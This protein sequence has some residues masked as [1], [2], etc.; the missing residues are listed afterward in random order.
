MLVT[1]GGALPSNSSAMVLEPLRR[2]GTR[3]E[4]RDLPP[5]WLTASREAGGVSSRRWSRVLDDGAEFS[6]QL[7]PDTTTS[8]FMST[9]EQSVEHRV[10]GKQARATA[11]W[12][13]RV[14]LTVP[15]RTWPDCVSPVPLRSTPGRESASTSGSWSRVRT[16]MSMP[17]G[18]AVIVR[19]DD[20][21]RPMIGRRHARERQQHRAREDCEPTDTIAVA[22]PHRQRPRSRAICTQFG[23]GAE[24]RRAEG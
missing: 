15:N 16:R 1:I 20:P 13:L 9:P 24:G 5:P 23:H 6:P 22:V 3:C 4:V 18:D 21:Q 2:D 7:T 11:G 8:A 19:H 12:P 10:G 14:L 17:G